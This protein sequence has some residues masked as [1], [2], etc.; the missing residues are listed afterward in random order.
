[1]NDLTDNPLNQTSTNLNYLYKLRL[2]SEF[3]EHN[4][5]LSWLEN[6]FQ[7]SF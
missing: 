3:V 4:K 5:K 2:V 7:Q 6:Y 1:M